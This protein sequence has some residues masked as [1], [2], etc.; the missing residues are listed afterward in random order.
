M[1]YVT[2][3][4]LKSQSD[5]RKAECFE[6]NEETMKH[7]NKAKRKPCG[8]IEN[9]SF[10]KTNLLQEVKSGNEGSTINY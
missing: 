8:P 2:R 6:S 4:S 1:S 3:I 10:D 5:L 7:I 9:M